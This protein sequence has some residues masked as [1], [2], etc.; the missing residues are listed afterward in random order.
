M[1]RKEANLTDVQLP[2][3]DAQSEIDISNAL[4]A[5]HSEGDPLSY[6]YAYEN[7][8]KFVESS[9]DIYKV[10]PLSFLCGFIS[11]LVFSIRIDTIRAAV[12]HI[13]DLL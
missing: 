6:T 10:S 3:N 13:G 7:L 2:A 4:S 11:A 5:Y 9:L 1:L 12:L 8:R